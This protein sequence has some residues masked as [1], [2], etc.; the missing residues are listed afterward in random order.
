MVKIDE[1]YEDKFSSNNETPVR[2][3]KGRIVQEPLGLD[4]PH[5]RKFYV[6]FTCG[7][8]TFLI[9]DDIFLV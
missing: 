5:L 2:Q 8:L 6:P 7:L 9:G 4:L 3:H 1:I